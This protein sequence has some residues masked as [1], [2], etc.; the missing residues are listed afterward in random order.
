[1]RLSFLRHKRFRPE[2]YHGSVAFCK[3]QRYPK[4]LVSTDAAAKLSPTWMCLPLLSQSASLSLTGS[5]TTM[6]WKIG[7]P[8]CQN[9]PILVFNPADLLDGDLLNLGHS[10]WEPG[11]KFQGFDVARHVCPVA[12]GLT[13]HHGNSWDAEGTQCNPTQRETRLPLSILQ[14]AMGLW[15]GGDAMALR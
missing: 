1:M 3:F 6:R 8:A 10:K 11:L 7:L 15:R 2:I 4:T 12:N 5:C 14:P 13:G 9:Q